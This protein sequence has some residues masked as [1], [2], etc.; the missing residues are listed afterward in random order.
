MATGS[1]G[2]YS[3]S[4]QPLSPRYKVAVY[5]GGSIRHFIH[6]NGGDGKNVGQFLK[7]NNLESAFTVPVGMSVKIRQI[8]WFPLIAETLDIKAF[9]SIEH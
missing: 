1:L 8:L 9:N 2:S 3:S 4:L 7:D 6:V 5:T